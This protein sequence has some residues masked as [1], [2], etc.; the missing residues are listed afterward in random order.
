MAC[1]TRLLRLFS[2]KG[3]YFCQRTIYTSNIVVLGTLARALHSNVTTIKTTSPV[4]S[5]L[6]LS[7]SN[8]HWIWRKNE[9][10]GIP[11]KPS[12]VLDLPNTL[13]WIPRLPENKPDNVIEAP[14]AVNS[15]NVKQAARLII[16]R[17]KKMKK[18][19]LKKLRLRMK[20]EWAKVRQRREWKKEKEF[21]AG[22]IAQCR[23][24][25]SFSAEGY[26]QERIN[27]LNELMAKK[28]EL[29]SAHT[30]MK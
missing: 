23:E 8:N 26:V 6:L 29:A 27:R 10:V 19:K 18:H 15:N 20:Y 17:R 12:A 30:K 25:E 28:E 24:A 2:A 16:I 5:P 1:A 4:L 21:Q 9:T 13:K 22:L 3:K 7:Q 11:V 14:S